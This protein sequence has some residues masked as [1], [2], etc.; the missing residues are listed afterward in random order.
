MIFPVSVRRHL[1]LLAHCSL[2]LIGLLALYAIPP[3][4]GPM[5][6]VPMTSKAR[7]SVAAQAV[8]GGARL[9]S[10]GPWMGSL[11]VDGERRRLGMP[12][13]RAGIVPL[14]ARAGGCEGLIG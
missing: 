14:A 12:L 10:A 13:L 11:L 4:R 6:L 9:I 2:M 3:V 5:L 1:V 7:R 8:S